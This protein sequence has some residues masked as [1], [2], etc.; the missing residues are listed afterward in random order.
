MRK[1]FKYTVY[2][3]SIYKGHITVIDLDDVTTLERIAVIAR[4]ATGGSCTQREKNILMM[5]VVDLAETEKGRA[6]QEEKSHLPAACLSGD[7]RINQI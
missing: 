1:H 5:M 4:L 6:I 3:Y 7:T 2:A